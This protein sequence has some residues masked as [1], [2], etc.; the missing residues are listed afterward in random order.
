MEQISQ[1]VNK[2]ETESLGI[3][4]SNNVT[5]DNKLDG[6]VVI[7]NIVN[8]KGVLSYFKAIADM[9]AT[10]KFE[11]VEKELDLLRNSLEELNDENQI[12]M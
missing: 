12:K 11:G 8:M 3:C 6:N 1:I 5:E 4:F 2:G 9:L 10:W 7:I